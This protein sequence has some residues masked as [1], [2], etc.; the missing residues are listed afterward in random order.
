MCYTYMYMYSIPLTCTCMVDSLMYSLF[1]YWLR[2]RDKATVKHLQNK[3]L[4]KIDLLLFQFCLFF[5]PKHSISN[6]C[7]PIFPIFWLLESSHHYLSQGNN[8]LGLVLTFC[9]SFCRS[10]HCTWKGRCIGD[11]EHCSWRVCIWWK[12][13][14]SW[15][16]KLSHNFVSLFV[17][18]LLNLWELHFHSVK[19]W[20]QIKWPIRLDLIPLSMA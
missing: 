11:K 4:L 1:R 2:N 13:N 6:T 7:F 20:I 10:I 12:K 8:F 17:Q 3:V 5:S 14:I 18:Q 19:V 15:C 9:D 16:K